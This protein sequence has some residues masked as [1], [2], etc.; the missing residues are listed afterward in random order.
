MANINTVWTSNQ[1]LLALQSLAGGALVAA[2]VADLSADLSTQDLV[3]LWV[4]YNEHPSATAGLRVG[5]RARN[6]LSGLGTDGVAYGEGITFNIDE[7][8]TRLETTVDADSSAGQKVL[9]VTATTNAV[10]GDPVIIAA[11]DATLEEVGIIASIQA[12]VS[13]TLEDNLANAHTAAQAHTVE[14]CKIKYIPLYGMPDAALLLYNLDASN[15][16]EV[17][18]FAASRDWTVV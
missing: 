1:Q 10:V 5:V 4:L 16:C 7:F 9:N 18:V 17:A 6:A 15:T 14:A 3:G 13:I 11:G 2:Q 8:G 12:G